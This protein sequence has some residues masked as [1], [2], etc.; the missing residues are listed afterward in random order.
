MQDS[1]LFIGRQYDQ[2]GN[3]KSWW[4][5]QTLKQFNERARCFVSQYENITEPTTGKNVVANK[6]HNLKFT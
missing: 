5:D 6:I 1:N 2:D 4:T 3:L